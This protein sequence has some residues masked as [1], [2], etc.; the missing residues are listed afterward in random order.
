MRENGA[1][2]KIFAEAFPLEPLPDHF[3]WAEAKGSLEG[4]IP[5][6]LKNRVLGR[7]WSEVT[8]MDWRMVGV[9]PAVSSQY[10]EPSTFAYYLPSIVLG[11]YP[12]LD[13]VEY[14][15][16]SILPRNQS[17]VPRGKWWAEFVD[18]ISRRQ[19][20]A[21]ATFLEDL[22]LNSWEAV[23]AANQHFLEVAESFWLR[24]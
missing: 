19:R 14:A 17:H 5:S 24:P 20:K 13:F 18:A 22:R 2:P 23:G 8:L 10:L 15:L 3:F 21:L 9:S 6:E 1:L 7:R 16:E 4:D 12:D 11:V